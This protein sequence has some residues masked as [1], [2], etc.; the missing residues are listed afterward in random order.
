M[1]WL[2][3][4]CEREHVD[5]PLCFAIEAPWRALVPEKEFAARV[6]LNSDQCVVDENTFFVRGHIQ[7]PIQG[8]FDKLEFSVWSSLSE[9]SFLHMC[10][11]WEAPDRDTDP[12]YFGWLCSP[13][14]V[15]PSTIHLKLSVQSRVPGLTPLFTVEPTDH[16]LAV[17]QQDGIS[18]DRWH[19]F[20]H[21]IMHD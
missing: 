21:Q 10:Q 11:R 5:A 7:I 17:D 13:I 1:S 2:C 3:K 19:E 4:L 16:P 15:Y 9:Q 18:V 8:R 6:L 14:C 20:A 12:P